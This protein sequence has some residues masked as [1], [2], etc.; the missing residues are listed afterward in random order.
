MFV[1]FSIYH[2]LLL[3][4]LLPIDWQ[5]HKAY[6]WTLV[7][8]SQAQWVFISLDAILTTTEFVMTRNKLKPLCS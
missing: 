8:Q 3:A 5:S 2:L 1:P 6:G 4:W 7:D